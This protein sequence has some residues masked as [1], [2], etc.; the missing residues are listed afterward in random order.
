[1]SAMP[2]RTRPALTLRRRFRLSGLTTPIKYNLF[3]LGEYHNFNA[4]VNNEFRFGFN[5]F[6][7]PFPVG[8]QTSLG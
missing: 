3:T 6:N 7:Q 5:R 4:N 2:S 1:M 8:S